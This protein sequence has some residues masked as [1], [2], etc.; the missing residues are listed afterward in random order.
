MR[1]PGCCELESALRYADLF[2]EGLQ[3]DG[4]G[5]VECCHAV[6]LP[7]LVVVR[8]RDYERM[9]PRFGLCDAIPLEMVSPRLLQPENAVEKVTR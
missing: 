5:I 8:A 6:L 9:V 4:A 3:V 7:I 2:S 1:H